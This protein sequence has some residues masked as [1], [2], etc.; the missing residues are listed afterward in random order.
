LNGRPRSPKKKAGGAAPP[1]LACGEVGA[2]G[3]D[4][5]HRPPAGATLRLDHAR[6]WIPGA[7]DPDDAELEVD[8]A[9]AERQQLAEAKPGVE[10]GRPDGAVFFA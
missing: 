8:V 9:V 10:R 2:E 5:R 4:D 7:L 6:V 1:Q 3:G